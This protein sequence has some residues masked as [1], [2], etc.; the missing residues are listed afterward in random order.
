[1]RADELTVAHAHQLGLDGGDTRASCHRKQGLDRRAPVARRH[2]L[3]LSDRDEQQLV[4]VRHDHVAVEQVAD[5]PAFQRAGAHL[6]RRCSL[7]TVLDEGQQV[8]A[9]GGRSVLGGAAGDVGQA[10]AAGDQP[11]AHFHQSDIAF[12]VG[13]TFGAVQRDLAATAQRQATHRRHGRHR[14][15]THSQQRVLQLLDLGLYAFGTQLHEGRQHGLQVGTS[16]EGFVGRPDH[17]AVIAAFR[18][19]DRLQQ[20][21]HHARA[22]QVHLA[23]DA[24]DQHLAVQCPEP[25]LVVLVDLGAGIDRR[26]GALAQQHL[27]ETLTRVH[28]QRRAGDGLAQRRAP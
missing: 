11:H 24:G 25:D 18:Q 17:Q 2:R 27:G 19:L 22:D 3:D 16:R 26:L 13:D 28:R 14:G 6:G 12:Q 15:V 1:M 5:L 20:P 7:E 21:L 9:V 23:G 8:G 4:L 10:A